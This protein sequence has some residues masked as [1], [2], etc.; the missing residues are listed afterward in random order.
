M[1]RRSR[2][3][4]LG[5]AVVLATAATGLATAAGQASAAPAAPAAAAAGGAHFVVLGDEGRNLG[6]VERAVRAAGGT[7]LKSWPQIGVVIATSTS[8]DFATVV[9]GKQGVRG[10]GA[11]RNLAELATTPPAARI[12]AA[13]GNAKTLEATEAVVTNGGKGNP[14]DPGDPLTVNQWN[15]KSIKADQAHARSGGSPNVVVGV[16]DSGIEATHPD[17][18]PNID[19]SRS[20]GCTNEGVP[21]TSPAAWAPTTSDHGTH[22]AGIIAAAKNGVG[23]VGVAP[24]VK[25]ASV[26]VVDDEGYIYPEY[27]IC[28][29]VWAAE[30]GIHV[31]NNSYFID[32]WFL[33]CRTDADQRAVI[34]AVTRAV[35]YSAHRGVVNVAALGNSNWDLSHDITDSGSPNN[36]TPVTRETGPECL[37]LPSEIDGVVGVSS[38]GVK[39]EKSYFSNYGI[40]ETDV[41][42]PGGDRMQI[43]TTPD[44]NGRVLSTVVGGAWGYKQGTSMA[45]PHAA[46]V[47]ALIRSTHRNWPAP[48]VIGALHVGADRQAC[49]SG[50][51][52]PDGTG[53]WLAT[54]E[55]GRSGRGFYGSGLIDALAA[56]R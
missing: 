34:T 26:K 46:G 48:L 45:S 13:Q 50:V 21:D 5:A 51:Y 7:V 20:V 19:A 35:N 39:N 3:R 55:G 42:A 18:A 9:R 17:L 4:L 49:P 53:A 23:V 10:A 15:L 30:K 41:A 38:T 12:A 8:A 14:T 47:V 27:A 11:T 36:G 16:L 43:P 1:H 24:N 32:P 29:F 54:C 56:V 28:G 44:A 2:L 31:T 33:W 6:Q 22:V 40:T 52:D 25:L 37:N